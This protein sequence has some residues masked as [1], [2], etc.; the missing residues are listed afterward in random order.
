MTEAIR[1][2]PEEMPVELWRGVK[3]S[4]PAWQGRVVSLFVAPKSAEEMVSSPMFE[5]WR[6]AGSKAIGF[7]AIR[8]TPLT[9]PI[10][11]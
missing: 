1:P 10:K 11:P 8:G 3:P 4:S 2:M 6:T 7:S 9:A 5:R